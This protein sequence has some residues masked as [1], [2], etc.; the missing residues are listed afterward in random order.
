MKKNNLIS[1]ALMLGMTLMSSITFANVALSEGIDGTGS[2]IS[3][4]PMGAKT[5]KISYGMRYSLSSGIVSEAYDGKAT[6]ARLDHL[7][8]MAAG[9]GDFIDFGLTLPYYKD[10]DP[11]EVNSEGI[12]DAKASFKLNYPPYKHKKGYEL[13]YVLQVGLPTGSGA[14]IDGFT[15]NTWNETKIENTDGS[16]KQ[17]AGAFDLDPKSNPYSAESIFLIMRLLNTIDLKGTGKALPLQIHFGAGLAMGASEHPSAFLGHI[18][19]EFWMGEYVALFYQLESESPIS[20]LQ[21]HPPLAKYPFLN[22]GGL[23]FQVPEIGLDFTLGVEA[24][25]NDKGEEFGFHYTRTNKNGNTY[26]VRRAPTT[27]V[28]AGLS[29]LW[30]FKEGD[31]DKD[32][33]MNNFDRCPLEAEDMDNFEDEDGC[34][35]MDNDQDGVPDMSDK[36]PLEA[37]DKDGFADEDGC[38]DPDD[39]RDGILDVNDSCRTEAEDMDGFQDTDGC[40]ELDND[41]DGIEDRFDQCPDDQEDLDEWKD[42]DGCPDRDND[43][44]GIPDESDEC[45]NDKEKINGIKD[46]D[47]CPD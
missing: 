14:Q 30:N 23:N 11:F 6:P 13:A 18:G 25:L 12:G 46:S 40:P 5:F 29:Y 15:R 26:K 47:G 16:F 45:P 44:D 4:V 32:G 22:K 34:P 10:K 42:E 9:L 20:A 27:Q 39:D 36:C 8:S 2:N 3:A 7:F 19:F 31:D 33:I 1:K 21:K 37:E 28:F 17:T 35:E 24:V 38:I 43:K 41:E